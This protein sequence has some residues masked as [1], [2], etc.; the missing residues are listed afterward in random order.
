MSEPK[1]ESGVLPDGFH[2]HVRTG[3]YE[4]PEDLSERE[5]V[6][7]QETGEVILGRWLPIR[8]PMCPATGQ[9]RESDVPSTAARHPDGAVAALCPRCS[10]VHLGIR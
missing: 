9:M 10:A 6:I 3:V 2:L 4:G 5:I 7:S 1:P 8:C